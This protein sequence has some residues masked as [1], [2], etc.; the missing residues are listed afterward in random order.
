MSWLDQLFNIR[1]VP[2]RFLIFLCSFMGLLFLLPESAFTMN[3]VPAPEKQVK[4]VFFYAII[5]ISFWLL[6]ALLLTLLLDSVHRYKESKVKK[7]I[8]KKFQELSLPEKI[9][10]REFYLHG[11]KTISAPVYDPAITDLL[12]KGIINQSS[13]LGSVTI[14]GAM[15]PITLSEETE[16]YL[17]V[18]LIGLSKGAM[19]EEDIDKIKKERP[20]WAR[21]NTESF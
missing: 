18:D 16:E 5:L 19:T 1:L 8:V 14:A 6:F 13:R 4:D 21:K 2:W 12:S 20:T 11:S 7:N 15:F 17:T 9:V 3:N 10:L